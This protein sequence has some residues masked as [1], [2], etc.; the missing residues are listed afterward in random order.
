M[1]CNLC[2]SCN[3]PHTFLDNKITKMNLILQGSV[4][5]AFQFGITVWKCFYH[6]GYMIFLFTWHINA[7]LSYSIIIFME[8]CLF[9]SGANMN[10]NICHCAF[11]PLIEFLFFTWVENNITTEQDVA[12]LFCIF[13]HPLPSN[14]RQLSS[15]KICAQPRHNQWPSLMQNSL[16]CSDLTF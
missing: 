15:T 12:S 4:I 14:I 2:I 1:E 8:T 6:N 3:I 13:F 5:L 10:V 7:P 16:L 11:L 9:S